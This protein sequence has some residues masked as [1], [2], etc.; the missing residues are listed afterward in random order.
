MRL[1]R[2]V[3]PNVAVEWMRMN[4]Q[5]QNGLCARFIDRI[6]EVGACCEIESFRKHLDLS[7]ST[8]PRK[9]NRG[10]CHDCPIAE[11]SL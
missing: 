6:I 3:N 10:R 7:N 5:I 4:G 9:A 2:V 8:R 1:F 11:P